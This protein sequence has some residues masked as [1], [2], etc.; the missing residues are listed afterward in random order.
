MGKK[1]NFVLDTNVILHD[2]NCLLNF[3]ENDVYLPIVLLEELDHFKKGNEQINFNARAFLRVL[4]EIS[5]ENDAV[6][7]EGVPTWERDWESYI[8]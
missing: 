6:F 8:S 5:E 4:D 3:E 1:K 7:T 2:Y